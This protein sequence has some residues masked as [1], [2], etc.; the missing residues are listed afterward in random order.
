[1]CH[2]LLLDGNFQTSI[3]KK[4]E[5]KDERVATAKEVRPP[6]VD[7]TENISQLLEEEIYSPVHSPLYIWE[8]HGGMPAALVRL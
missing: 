1:M 7:G 3:E 8:I 4:T 6:L 5:R 2:K